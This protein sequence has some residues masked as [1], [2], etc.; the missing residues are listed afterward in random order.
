MSIYKLR[1]VK[2]RG[3]DLDLG[4]MPTMKIVTPRAVSVSLYLYL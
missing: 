2:L 3:G 4:L 1:D